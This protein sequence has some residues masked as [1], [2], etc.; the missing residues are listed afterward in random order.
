MP[1]IRQPSAKA[2]SAT[3]KPISH[4]NV[5]KSARWQGNPT[6]RPLTDAELEVRDAR[7]QRM[8]RLLRFVLIVALLVFLY[9]P[10]WVVD[11]LLALPIGAQPVVLRVLPY[12]TRA[13]LWLQFAGLLLLLALLVHLI[14]ALVLFAAQ[15]RNRAAGIFQTLVLDVAGVPAIT[16]LHG[17]DLFV[18]LQRLNRPQGRGR[19]REET[20]VFAL[21]GGDDGRMQLRV[22]G[23]ALRGQ[24]DWS[25]FL[26]Q[27]I[28]GRAPG[29]TARPAEDDLVVALKDVRPGHILA[30]ADLVL[31]RDGSYPLNDLGQ[32]TTDPMGPLAAALRGGQHINYV[33]YEIILRAVED[34]WRQ[35]VRAQVAQIQAKLAPDDLPGHDALLT[36]AAQ[37]AYDVVVRCIVIADD[38]AH[39]RAQLADMREALAQFDRTTRN[40]TQRLLIPAVD[41]LLPG[42]ALGQFVPIPPAAAPG[43]RPARRDVAIALGCA[44]LGGAL[45]ASIASGLL[46]AHWPTLAALLAR[47][48]RLSIVPNHLPRLPFLSPGPPI[49]SP[50]F[51]QLTRACIGGALGAVCGGCLARYHSRDRVQWRARQAIS[52]IAAHAHR[53]AWPG[54]VWPIPL[55]GK[56]RGVM[57][58]FDLAALWHIPDAGLDTLMTY[59]GVRYLPKPRAVFLEAADAD[60]AERR[61]V[62]PPPRNP[63]DLARRRIALA[64][65]D[66]PDGTTGLIGP[67]VRDLRKGSECLGPM[68]SGKSCYIETLAVEL[69]RVG[70]GFGLIDAKGDL[71]DRLLAA[72]PR[73]AQQRVVVIDVG[74]GVV[75]CINPLDARLLRA[76]IPLETLAGQV[77]QLF[78]RIDPEMWHTSMG[79]QQFCRYGLYALLEGEPRGSLL[80]LNLLYGSS[81]YREVVLKK[82]REPQVINF[83][84]AEYP[85]MDDT[86]RR[87]IESFRRRLQRFITAPLV[88]QLFCQPEST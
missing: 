22:R 55:P 13:Y 71:A 16:P 40:A 18:G 42:G 52:R 8:L 47:L 78:A 69:A 34:R 26:R 67:A 28:E 85:A 39:A 27:Q 77:E 84:R 2:R 12:L 73:E 64:Y 49:L 5:G 63:L 46:S 51:S 32:F 37:A 45:G 50:P 79:M 1:P 66:R 24:R 14:V 36:K 19:G 65:A 29:T 68:G 86:L 88:Q 9:A 38:A 81:A 17:V 80:R 15:R 70:S 33:A 62:L 75:P 6:T 60:A 53:F 41:R 23:H 76:G 56:R 30:W 10:Q 4:Q 61:A 72:L 82:V 20:F 87:S 7:Q 59:R 44:A 35:P 54:P 21:V 48:P 58:A 74:G 25:S 31:L 3:A 57:G 43:Q 83:W 11:K